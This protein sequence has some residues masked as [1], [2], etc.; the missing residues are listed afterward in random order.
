VLALIVLAITSLDKSLITYFITNLLAAILRNLTQLT[1]NLTQL[2]GLYDIGW[3]LMRRDSWQR[4]HQFNSGLVPAV[5]EEKLN[6]V[7]SWIS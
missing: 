5:A 3:Y 7:P 4:P 1:S 6:A 2:R